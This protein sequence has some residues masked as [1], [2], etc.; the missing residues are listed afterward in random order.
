MERPQ[1][2]YED[3]VKLLKSRLYSLLDKARNYK[4]KNP[5]EPEIVKKAKLALLIDDDFYQ[6]NLENEKHPHNWDIMRLKNHLVGYDRK[7]RLAASDIDSLMNS[8]YSDSMINS[9][10]WYFI[11]KS[12]ATCEIIPKSL[13]I[14]IAQSQA[15]R[16]AIKDALESA[17]TEMYDDETLEQ[18]LASGYARDCF[19]NYTKF[20]SFPIEKL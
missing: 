18:L 9:S 20:K 4:E 7:E 12:E 15:H 8:K 1:Q 14:G 16:F 2:T 11:D 3:A 5:P 6:I 10:D 17:E 19:E 13:I